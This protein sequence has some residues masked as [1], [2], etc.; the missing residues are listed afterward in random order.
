MTEILF[1]N[2]IYSLQQSGGISSMW[3]MLQKGLLSDVEFQ[4]SFIEQYQVCRNIFRRKLN[5]PFTQI[6]NTKTI[7]PLA[8][9]RYCKVNIPTTELPHIFH[10]SYYRVH[11]RDNVKTIVTVHDFTYEKFMSGWKRNIHC[12]QKHNAIRKADAIV[13][14]S[15]NTRTDLLRYLPDVN[16]DKIQVIY[17]GIS[18][19][20]YKI[21]NVER[22]DRLL[23]VGGRVGYKNFEMLIETLSLTSHNLDICGAPL[24]QKEKHFIDNKL[25]ES[26]YKVY[27]HIDNHQLNR[28]YNTA[29][30]LVYPS[31]YEGFGLPIVEAQ[32]T[33]CPVI[34]LNASSIPEIIGDTPLLMQRADSKSLHTAL[35]RLESPSILSEVVDAGE[36]NANRFSP[37]SMTTAYKLLYHHL[38]AML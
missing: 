38:D 15:H 34:A 6:Y 3:A 32:K 29:K 31:A 10:S 5:I 4:C 16:P 20:F 2:I 26:R 7:L 12:R 21:K 14:V 18:D 33:G 23:Y 11:S 27:S 30:C 13:C 28:L 17:N 22:G 8:V 36:I 19:D 25:G 24:T 9:G 35:N 37:Q 1:D